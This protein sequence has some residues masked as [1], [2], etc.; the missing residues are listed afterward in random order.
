MFEYNRLPSQRGRTYHDITKRTV[1]AETGRISDFG[2]TTNTLHRA[3][4]YGIS[5]V[6]ISKKIGHIALYV[7]EFMKEA[8]STPR[9][10]L[11]VLRIYW[12]SLGWTGKQIRDH[13][14]VSRWEKINSVENAN[15]VGNTI[16]NLYNNRGIQLKRS[17]MVCSTFILRQVTSSS[18]ECQYH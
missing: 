11:Y 16:Y 4:T 18:S 15:Y 7:M 17:N 5:I 10:S 9:C 14:T 13:I 12:H 1:I 3:L 6:R 8:C 2:V